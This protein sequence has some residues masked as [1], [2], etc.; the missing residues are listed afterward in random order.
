[1]LPRGLM[2]LIKLSK[3]IIITLQSIQG[4]FIHKPISTIKC[5]LYNPVLSLPQENCV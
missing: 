5:P 1:M 4:I 2:W 3:L